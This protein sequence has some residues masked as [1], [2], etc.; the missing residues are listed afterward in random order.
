MKAVV[1]VIAA[2]ML[3]FGGASVA[4]AEPL[5]APAAGSSV[6][7]NPVALPPGDTLEARAGIGAAI[8]VVLGGLAGLPF[9]VVGAIPGAVI[10][11]LAGAGI[12]A[13]SWNI[14]NA[15]FG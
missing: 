2:V 15:Y 7:V 3:M 11:G 10:G 1:A 6:Q 9:A 14:A 8:G 13:A 4:A 12:G 5:P